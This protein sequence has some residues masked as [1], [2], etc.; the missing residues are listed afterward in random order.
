MISVQEAKNIIHQNLPQHQL[1]LVKLPD[2]LGKIITEDIFASESSPRCINSL[3]GLL[4]NSVASLICYL[5]YVYPVIEDFRGKDFTWAMAHEKLTQPIHNLDAYSKMHE[6]E[7]V[8][9]T[10]FSWER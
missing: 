10:L 7:Q 8:E 1:E 9:V 2:A 4:G 5:Y 6:G 3:F